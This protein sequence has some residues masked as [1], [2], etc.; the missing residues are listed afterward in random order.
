MSLPRKE[1]KDDE[2]IYGVYYKHHILLTICTEYYL[3][4]CNKLEMVDCGRISR[5]Q[6]KIHSV[7]IR[8]VLFSPCGV[9]F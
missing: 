4:E 1:I 5:E 2:D 8:F 3:V 7:S 9:Y 6:I